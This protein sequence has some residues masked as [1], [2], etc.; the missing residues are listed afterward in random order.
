LEDQI[1]IRRLGE[2]QKFDKDIDLAS[3]HQSVPRAYRELLAS[4]KEQLKTERIK[5]IPTEVPCELR[6]LTDLPVIGTS[7]EEREKTEAKFAEM[8]KAIDQ[9]GDSDPP[10]QAQGRQRGRDTRPMPPLDGTLVDT[11]IEFKYNSGWFNGGVLAVSDGS[12]EHAFTVPVSNGSMYA[13]VL[14]EDDDKE[15]WVHLQRMAKVK[16]AGEDRMHYNP[17]G[18]AFQGAWRLA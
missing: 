4:V 8:I 9:A 13:L 3:S 17:P 7:C 15:E 10:E 12:T 1:R 2:L 5:P 18:R 11:D 6:A 14:F 16:G